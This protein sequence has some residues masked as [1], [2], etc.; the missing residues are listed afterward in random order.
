MFAAHL[1]VFSSLYV[2]KH[3]PIQMTNAG[4]GEAWLVIV[5]SKIDRAPSIPSAVRHITNPKSKQGAACKLTMIWALLV[6]ADL[7]QQGQV[8]CQHSYAQLLYGCQW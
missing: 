1:H 6:R 3:K 5:W 2:L 7:L 8:E 4:I